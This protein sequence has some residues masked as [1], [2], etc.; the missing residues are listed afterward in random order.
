MSKLGNTIFVGATALTASAI[1]ST[2]AFQNNT[3]HADTTN[4]NST[5]SQTTKSK[6]VKLVD[7]TGKQLA[8]GTITETDTPNANGGTSKSFSLSKSIPDG[9]EL[10]DTHDL[11]QYPDT[12]T[13]VKK[14]SQATSTTNTDAN[15]GSQSTNQTTPATN[16]DVN[17]GGQSTSQ[18]TPATN[19][20]VNKGGQNTSQTTSTTNTDSN[21]AD[22]NNATGGTLV[23]VK[24]TPSADSWA[25]KTA[26]TSTNISST[27]K[28][29]SGDSTNNIFDFKANGNA[30]SNIGRIGYAGEGDETLVTTIKGKD[31]K[32]Y[33]LTRTVNVGNNNTSSSSDENTPVAH[34]VELPDVTIKQHSDYTPFV[35][36]AKTSAGSKDLAA[37]VTMNGIG[38]YRM[39]WRFGDTG[40]EQLVTVKPVANDTANDSNANN[41]GTTDN[42]S[43]SN[44]D[45]NSGQSTSTVDP[46][47]NNGSTTANDSNNKGSNANSTTSN[48][49][50][51]SRQS[52]STVD[53]NANSG[54]TASNASNNKGSNANSTTSN[55]ENNSGQ[56]TSTVDPNANS[57]STASNASNNKGS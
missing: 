51:N 24:A 6:T 48:T 10:K 20:D 44:T 14:G 21:K 17:K 18:T 43:T 42:K 3:V 54:S 31:G 8:T 49:E 57:G 1:G 19:T 27:A 12:I 4:A 9:Y 39:T 32:T 7:E 50:N 41:K 46:N 52:T 5:A 15:K 33:T 38:T 47:T 28:V 11:S 2:L 36:Q 56:S 26:P 25:D 37:K 53:P 34:R 16:T 35:T 30:L 40:F 29:K 55:T 23:E 13:L 22:K 45:N